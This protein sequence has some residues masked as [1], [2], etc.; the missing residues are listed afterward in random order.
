VAPPSRH[1]M[2]SLAGASLVVL[3]ALVVGFGGGWL[4][5]RA[6]AAT[7]TTTSSTTTSSSSTTSS[8]GVPVAGCIGTD[9]VGTFSSS[10]AAAGT[11]QAVFTVNDVAPGACTLDGYP[12]LQLLDANM[13]PLSAQVSDGGTSFTPAKA[14]LAPMRLRLS[15]VT[16]AAFVVQ[17]TD[18]PA[19]TQTTC[20]AA[21]ALNVYPP[22]SATAFN[23]TYAFTPCNGGAVDVSPFFLTT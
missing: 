6:T 12:Q 13:V 11:V 10:S 3:L 22:G 14:N 1:R 15:A 17:F 5:R 20:P 4:V 18:V 21:A 7:T 9:L 8:T 23:V 16:H 19:G 2:V